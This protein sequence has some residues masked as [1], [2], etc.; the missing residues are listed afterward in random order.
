MQLLSKSLVHPKYY[1][2]T[3][4]VPRA[5]IWSDLGLRSAFGGRGDPAGHDK[6]LGSFQ[7]CFYKSAVV[8]MAPFG[9]LWL[10]SFAQS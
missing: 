9:I 7:Q 8:R 1:L 2:L 10:A 6:C 5:E 3:E 4:V